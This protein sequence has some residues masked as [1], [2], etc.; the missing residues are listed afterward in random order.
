MKRKNISISIIA[1]AILV[2]ALGVGIYGT[3][4]AQ[5]GKIT[6]DESSSELMHFSQID[7]SALNE[8]R[9]LTVNRGETI[10]IPVAIHAAMEK[11][12][13][14]K[15]GITSDGQET[16]LALT[17]E[18]ILPDG[19]R[20]NSD[21]SSF[22]FEALEQVGVTQR[23]SANITISIDVNAKAGE[24]PLSLVL[25]EKKGDN[26]EQVREYFTLKVE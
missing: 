12:K 2:L 25:Y 22:G 19:I 14:L 9:V 18:S 7:A 8:N 17:G 26:A 15:F 20:A 11:S 3:E 10:Q 1:S 13:N 4:S 16:I 6:I 24:Y 5:A 23:D 21:K